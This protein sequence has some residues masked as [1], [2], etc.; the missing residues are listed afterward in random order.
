VPSAYNILNLPAITFH[1]LT[2]S[3][4]IFTTLCIFEIVSFYKQ[5]LSNLAVIPQLPTFLI[6]FITKITIVLPQKSPYIQNQFDKF[7]RHYSRND[8]NSLGACW[9]FFSR[10]N[11]Y[12]LFLHFLFMLIN[13]Y[14]K[15]QLSYWK[16]IFIQFS[17]HPA[18]VEHSEYLHQQREQMNTRSKKKM[19]IQ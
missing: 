5:Y 10:E 18:T 16:N 6:L 15:W 12:Q 14:S 8:D 4:G 11:R 7:T 2:K 19:G 17:K 1:I 9:L 3:H 13:W